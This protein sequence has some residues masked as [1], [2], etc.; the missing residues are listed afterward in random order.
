VNSTCELQVLQ[1]CIFNPHIWDVAQ[2]ED[3]DARSTCTC[4]Y[5]AW[6]CLRVLACAYWCMLLHVCACMRACTT[7]LRAHTEWLTCCS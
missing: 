5:V 3:L 4:F 2:P 6:V 7:L 1:W